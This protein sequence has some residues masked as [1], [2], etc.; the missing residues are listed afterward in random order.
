[1]VFPRLLHERLP[2]LGIDVSIVYPTLG[3]SF[4]ARDREGER[5]KG[6]RAV[7]RYL[8]DAFEGCEDRLVP[9]A[10]VPMHTPSEASEELEH[11]VLALGFKA[12][13]LPSYVRRPVPAVAEEFPA[14]TQYAF[15]L[16]TYGIDSEFDYDPFWRR[17]VEL[18]V[19]PAFHS[20]TI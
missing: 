2:E 10:L 4:A 15:R 18:G 8:A 19:A 7:N 16:D 6:C 20:G 9:V 13:V 3:F 14:A 17:C 5:R 1:V 11:A 12:I